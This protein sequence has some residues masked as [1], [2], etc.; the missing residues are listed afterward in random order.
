MA[1]EKI[2]VNVG[3]EV[4]ELEA[5]II[6]TPG[7]EVERVT[8]QNAER[9]LYS[10]ILNL[11]AVRKEYTQF[12]SILEKHT[13]TLEVS[14]L[15]KDIL[16]DVKVKENLLSKI[17]TN[18]KVY[19]QKKEFMEQSPAELSQNLIEGVELKKNNLT[20]YLSNARYFLSPLHNF[21]FTR[22]ASATINNNVFI[23]RMANNVRERE[24]IIMEAIFNYHPL[25]SSHTYN[26]AN[27]INFDPSVTIEG[28]D[29]IVARE[30]T[31]IIGKSMRTTTQGVDYILEKV[32][33][34][35]KIKNIIVQELPGSPESFI[36]L[37]M[38]FT[39]LS[40]H[41]VMIYEPVILNPNQFKTILIRIDKQNVNI[42]ERRDILETLKEI[43]CEVEPVLCG[44]NTDSWIQERE[45]WHSGANLFAMG[46]GKLL[47]YARNTYTLDELSKRGYE[48]IKA[49][50]V[51]KKKKNFKEYEKYVITIDSSELAR[52][53]G[54]C[55]CMT[56][57]IK[58]KPLN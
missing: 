23:S 15:L 35:G 2:D 56:M 40:E 31:L 7:S 54:G 58:R 27:Q 13:L 11:S 26:P 17:C 10:D 33:D 46:P 41:E 32:K 12:K 43:K 55:R 3:S 18:E 25:L 57:P 22:D 20:N 8:P 36:H 21:F 42:S 52:G 28:G 4:G 51:I 24:A 16:A 44:G 38:A 29:L 49:N 6:H 5:V 30:D 47:A 9:A 50:E 48:I 45:Q 37:D 14:D 1:E 19:N 39:F 53:G 34:A